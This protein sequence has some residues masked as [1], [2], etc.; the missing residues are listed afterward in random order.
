MKQI[1]NYSTSSE[2]LIYMM[3]ITDF[4]D[5]FTANIYLEIYAQREIAILLHIR[6]RIPPLTFNMFT[7]NIIC[8]I[9]DTFGGWGGGAMSHVKR[10]FF[11]GRLSM[12][13]WGNSPI[14][15]ASIW[16]DTRRTIWIEINT[17]EQKMR[18]IELEHERIPD[19]IGL[20]M[21]LRIRSSYEGTLIGN[22]RARSGGGRGRES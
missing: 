21:K 20:E 2:F 11:L 4:R 8:I 7:D 19:R 22:W 15:R 17:I 13:L 14:L 12:L 6:P 16:S 9:F 18:L 10:G 5:S 3:K 1:I